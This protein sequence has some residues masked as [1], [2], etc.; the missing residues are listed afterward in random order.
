MYFVS[1]S[2]MFWHQFCEKLYIPPNALETGENAGN[3]EH[4][5]KNLYQND[6]FLNV[7]INQNMM[8]QYRK[9]YFISIM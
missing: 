6:F 7:Y 9:F 1:S 3:E 8:N 4:I 5:K 2:I